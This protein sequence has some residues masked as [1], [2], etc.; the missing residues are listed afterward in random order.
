MHLLIILVVGILAVLLAA[1][2]LYWFGLYFA[3]PIILA[4]AIWWAF[5]KRLGR[6]A[7]VLAAVAGVMVFY[8]NY[9]LQDT[10]DTGAGLTGR[11]LALWFIVPAVA[12]LPLYLIGYVKRARAKKERLRAAA[13]LRAKAA[14]AR[15]QRQAE[16]AAGA[17]ITRAE[18][19]AAAKARA[20]EHTVQALDWLST[21]GEQLAGDAA[22][23]VVQ[24]GLQGL[25]RFASWWNSPP[26]A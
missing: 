23:R 9:H 25:Q 11:W 22:E 18:R 16:I 26:K 3:G 12:S 7:A 19:V 17:P 2:L 21:E 24:R 13:E 14:A 10:S 1:V 5:G 15:A 6:P 8:A 20:A 4:G